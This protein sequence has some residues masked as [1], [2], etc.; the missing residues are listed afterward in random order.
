MSF[1]GIGESYAPVKSVDCVRWLN[2]LFLL[3]LVIMHCKSQ[4]EQ[5]PPTHITTLFRALLKDPLNLYIHLRGT[6]LMVTFC[7]QIAEMGHLN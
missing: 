2:G 3:L 1:G 5:T 6:D 4:A 7:A